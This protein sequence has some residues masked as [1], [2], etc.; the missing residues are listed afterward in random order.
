MAPFE[1]DTDRLS[2]LAAVED[3]QWRSSLLVFSESEKARLYSPEAQRSMAAFSTEEH[4]RS[5]FRGLTAHE[6]LNRMLEAEFQTF[7]PDQVLTFVDRL[8]MAHSLEVRSPYLDT[9]VVTFVASLPDRMKI[10]GGS[11]KYLLKQ[12]ALVISRRKW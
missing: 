6:P 12:A 9:D 5:V 7:L 1:G 3:W 10:R 4:L 11:T 2:R 8:S